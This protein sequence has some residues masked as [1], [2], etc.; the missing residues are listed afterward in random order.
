VAESVH[1]D[2]YANEDQ[3]EHWEAGMVNGAQ[4]DLL[5]RARTAA[6]HD[7]LGRRPVLAPPPP[8]GVQSSSAEEALRELGPRTLVFTSYLG[9]GVGCESTH[10]IRDA[11]CTSSI[12]KA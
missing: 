1:Q 4:A 6:D 3:A 11:K 7:I 5:V 10:E 2:R 8:P 9:T 12:T